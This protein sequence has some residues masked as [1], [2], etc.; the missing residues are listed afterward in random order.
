MKKRST[1]RY[2]VL[3]EYIPASEQ[4][5]IKRAVR[6]VLPRVQAPKAFVERLSQ[7]L[8]VAARRGHH[9]D[10]HYALRK[11][12]LVGGSA[13]SVVGGV[14]IWFLLKKQR[15][16]TPLAVGLTQQQ[17]QPASIGHV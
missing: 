12:G 5:A 17:N 4:K 7:D 14:L 15:E 6:A 13:L 3:Q 10:P 16:Q 9:G 11:Y 2:V 1:T 8:I